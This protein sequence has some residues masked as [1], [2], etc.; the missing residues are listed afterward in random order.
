[1]EDL[2]ISVFIPNFPH[3]KYPNFD[4]WMKTLDNYSDYFNAE[5]VVIGHSLGVPFSLAVLEKYKI[6]SAF[7]VAGFVGKIDHPFDERIETFS[8]RDFNWD[9]IK[10]HCHNF[11]IYHSDNDPY[12][13]LD[14]AERVSKKLDVP[15]KIIPQAG[16]F[17][18]AS[19][20]MEFDILL[21]DLL[22]NF[23]NQSS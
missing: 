19:S 22:L 12:L 21:N 5:T 20:Y 17:N 10:E 7:F 11:H 3:S 14:K 8:Q 16:H 23:S 13:S 1:M 18:E 15:I 4:S 6:Y 9:L 2:G